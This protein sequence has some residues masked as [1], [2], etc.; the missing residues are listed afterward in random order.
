[1][2]HCLRPETIDMRCTLEWRG[3]IRPDAKEDV[4]NGGEIIRHEI[5]KRPQGKEHAENG[6]ELIYRPVC[7]ETVRSFGNPLTSKEPGTAGITSPRGEG[8]TRHET[9]SIHYSLC[10]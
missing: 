1:M 3:K 7:M 10:L 4:L 8:G 6:I 9:I 2:L 5:R